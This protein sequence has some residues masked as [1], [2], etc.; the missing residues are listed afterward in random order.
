MYICSRK[1]RVYHREDCRHAR[2]IL[3][4]NHREFADEAAARDAGFA[5]CRCCGEM[6]RRHR[7][8]LAQLQ[9]FCAD[10]RVRCE[11]F[12]AALWLKTP[13]CWWKLKPARNGGF[14]LLHENTER[15]G[16]DREVTPFWRR[17]Y[18]VQNYQCG[19]LL[20]Y[21][22]YTVQH[23]KWRNG[24]EH[25][26]TKRQKADAKHEAARRKRK[27]VACVMALLDTLATPGAQAHI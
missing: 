27:A 22:Q 10:N 11:V 4:G 9:D 13:R 3:P 5:V 21:A 2:R 19:S 16:Y 18:H 6:G 25:P 7:R 23:D 1:S 12:D 15:I 26:H 17:E 14:T 20:K 8:A 24:V